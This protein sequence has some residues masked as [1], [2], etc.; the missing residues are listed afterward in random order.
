MIEIAIP[1]AKTLRL[2]TA[3]IDFN[4]TLARDGQLHDGVAERLQVLA[5]QLAIHVVT[6]DTTGTARTALDGLPVE[7]HIV[8]DTGQSAAK[9]AFL[10]GCGAHEVV[11]IGNGRN[12]EALVD[13]AELSIVVIGDEGCAART[14]AVA[15]IVCTNIRD[16]LDLLLTPT[17]LM[18]TLR[19]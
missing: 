3:I 12:D 2:S 7:V 5:R 6:A 4:G 17:R 19:S 8:Q 16:A 13:A 18:A 11:A 14:L 1:G 9:R 10:E 15:D